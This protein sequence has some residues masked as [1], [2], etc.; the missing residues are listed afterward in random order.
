MQHSDA[1]ARAI[2]V[3]ASWAIAALVLQVSS[4]FASIVKDTID[5][6]S[7]VVAATVWDMDT[8]ATAHAVIRESGAPSAAAALI[9]SNLPRLVS[10][11]ARDTNKTAKTQD[12]CLSALV[13]SADVW[14]QAE[15]ALQR[16]DS[17]LLEQD[18]SVLQIV[19]DALLV[20][21]DLQSQLKQ[22]QSSLDT[23]AS[24]VLDEFSHLLWKPTDCTVRR[25]NE[26]GDPVD[27][28]QQVSLATLLRYA[29]D[30]YLS[31][32]AHSSHSPPARIQALVSHTCRSVFTLV[33]SL[34]V[35]ERLPWVRILHNAALMTSQAGTTST[36]E[37]DAS[38]M[39][40]DTDVDGAAIDE[41]NSLSDAAAHSVRAVAS[42]L[43]NLRASS[44]GVCVE[45]GMLQSPEPLLSILFPLVSALERLLLEQVSA[46]LTRR[47]V[48]R[49]SSESAFFRSIPREDLIGL[50]GAVYG[51]AC[52]ASIALLMRSNFVYDSNLSDSAFVAHVIRLLSAL[53]WHAQ[54]DA[55]AASAG[56][57]TYREEMSGISSKTGARSVVSGHG[58]GLH[59]PPARR[60]DE[61]PILARFAIHY[62]PTVDA[63][64]K[65]SWD[66]SIWSTRKFSLQELSC[67]KHFVYP[68]ML[69]SILDRAA[70]HPGLNTRPH[71]LAKHSLFLSGIASR[72]D[73][74]KRLFDS[75]LARLAGLRVLRNSAAQPAFAPL[76]I[77]LTASLQHSVAFGGGWLQRNLLRTWL[78]SAFWA[79]GADPT[80][81]PCG[82]FVGLIRGLTLVADAGLP[83][84]SLQGFY[85]QLETLQRVWLPLVATW[86]D[87]EQKA[88]SDVTDP[89]SVE[90]DA[91]THLSSRCASL[92]DVFRRLF[93][94]QLEVYR[95]RAPLQ[96]EI[97]TALQ[98]IVAGLPSSLV[99]LRM[100]GAS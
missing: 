20:L 8:R 35:G 82:I 6:F 89:A 22:K 27:C 58:H 94:A 75:E 38:G 96:S 63:T 40:D 91:T 23:S 73:S 56:L 2:N 85:S 15:P 51:P 87:Q 97:Q 77:A 62:G 17:K 98:E 48:T 90:L 24:A 13:A 61:R 31:K 18:L 43:K 39:S 65:I 54:L 64:A 3:Q 50:A 57:Q 28:V 68:V 100:S 49:S 74:S 42:Q 10:K 32:C 81:V 19:A 44:L 1:A 52:P 12:N 69:T 53:W 60:T 80:M 41:I 16:W 26:F 95:Q 7:S 76:R 83:V 36:S 55:V 70:S 71:V 86:E 11:D 99:Q 30:T 34:L 93:W 29:V 46:W 21:T 14:V 78:S 67:I 79:M 92:P 33:E 25:V 84:R 88:E 59:S 5:A 4:G 47:H 9:S 72:H 66:Q 45:S 37:P